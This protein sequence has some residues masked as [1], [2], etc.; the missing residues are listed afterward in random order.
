MKYISEQDIIESWSNL[1]ETNEKNRAQLNKFFGLLEV[2]KQLNIHPNGIVTS[3][4][5]YHLN[6]S[7]LSEELQEKYFFGKDTK[8]YNSVELLFA[9]FPN[10]WEDNVFNAFLKSN[11][12]SIKEAAIICMQ[13]EIFDDSITG[14]KL[15]VQ[16]IE[17]HH[18]SNVSST[19]FTDDKSEINFQ[20]SKPNRSNIFK[21]LK[22][23]FSLSDNTK[24]TLGF[25][26]SLIAAN[27][28]ELTRG[29]FIQPLYSGQENLKCVLLSSFNFIEQ[30]KI[31]NEKELI[32][33]SYS[34][35]RY[36]LNQIL[37]GAPGTGKTHNA[38][39]HALAIATGKDLQELIDA[40]KAN[41]A[42][43][44]AA[45]D[46]FDELVKS[47]QIQFVTFHQS[48]SYEEFVEGI[49]PSVNGSNVEYSIEEGIFKKLCLKANEKMSIKNFDSLYSEFI[50]DLTESGNQ[51]QLT[52]LIQK[53]PFSVRI[54]S[55][56]S[57]VAIPKT[58]TATEMTITKKV[59]QNFMESGIV[60]DWKPYTTS[61]AK[62]ITDKYKPKTEAEDNT[63]KNFVLIIDE[64]NRGNISKIFGELIT[65]IEDSKRLGN[66]EALKIK[67]TYSGTKDKEMFG[68]PNNVYIVGTM[69]SADRSIALIDTALRRRFTFTE[70][71][72]DPSTLSDNIEGINLK[73]M[74]QKLNERIEFLLDKDHLLGH[75]YFLDVKTKNDLC[76][77]FRNKILPLLEEYFFGNNEKIQQVLGD[78]SGWKKTE[79]QKLIQEKKA[80][81]TTALFG[82]TEDFED[83]IIYQINPKLV[84][85][86]F[87]EITAD[88]FTSI[89]TKL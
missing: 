65:L 89:Y 12:I 22:R 14:R 88:V 77:V 34:E 29:P 61:I 48:Y 75:A 80:N 76:G 1:I 30:Y 60:D 5:Q 51:L 73:L 24:N 8:E 16:F 10:N 20:S 28:G 54:N 18:L 38:I 36:P 52:T 33:I 45:K 43:R 84:E 78:N 81:T 63:N 59:I 9:I 83:K 62:Y 31:N 85:G 47:G 66:S 2:L 23:R 79:E 11:A 32:N 7:S 44:K 71:T 40:E 86:K 58:T 64:I 26:K 55:N 17:K 67:L 41:P 87:D 21:E 50:S 82:N 49:K 13:T 3:G 19:F 27:S 35:N 70:Y 4:I 25:D 68:V 56:G 74:L 37:Y 69:N 53:K 57:C 6:S 39:N 72:S 46:E 42:N 15:K